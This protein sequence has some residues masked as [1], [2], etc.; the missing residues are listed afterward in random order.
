[1]DDIFEFVGRYV[2]K[3]I[4]RFVSY[5]VIDIIIECVIEGVIRGIRK[6]RD[7]IRDKWKTLLALIDCH[8]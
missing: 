1:M 7:K 8:D 2:I 3:P 5:R 4:I 6:L